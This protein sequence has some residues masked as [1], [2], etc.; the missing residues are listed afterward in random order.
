MSEHLINFGENVVAL[1]YDLDER[2]SQWDGLRLAMVRSVPAAFTRDEWAYLVTFLDHASLMQPFEQSFGP[3]A[4]GNASSLVRA[5]GSIALWLPNN[6]SLLGPLVL[7]LC[8]FTGAPIRVKAGSRSDD[9]CKAFV[10]CALEHLPQGELR[11]YLSKQVS[12]GQFDRN[13]E[14]NRTMAAEASVRIAFGSDAATNAIHSLPH[15]V[16]SVGISFADHRSEAW[17]QMAALDDTSITTLI[18]VFS[19]YGQAGCT[20]PRRVVIIDGTAADCEA[21]RAKMV[22]LWP[23]QEVPMHIAS[24]NILH[25]QLAAASGW[26]AQT[27]PR[28]AAVLGVGS[29]TN[30]EMTGLMSLAIVSATAQEAAAALP[31]NIQ[32]VGHCL[33]D[34]G[35]V[36][37]LSLIARTPIKR[38]VPAG[39]MHHFGAVWDGMN[40]WRQ[41]FEETSIRS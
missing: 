27:A 10:S 40:F 8:S 4:S 39:Q 35:A 6:V 3:L 26:D 15:P 23:K 22:A 7:I 17:V 18:K 21:L 11:D 5:R 34:A 19:I 30:A 38:W 12:I 33:A 29:L 9:L 32:T 13:D 1:S 14:R 24:Q 16:H 2:L 25:C 41:L 28:N 37:W 20:S 31:A 36:N